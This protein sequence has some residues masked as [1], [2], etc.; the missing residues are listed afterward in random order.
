[1]Q[2]YDIHKYYLGKLCKHNHNYLNTNNTLRR[3]NGG[4]CVTCEKNR[5]KTIEY[6]IKNIKWIKNWR[7]KQSKEQKD[8]LKLLDAKNKRFLRA[9]DYNTLITGRLHSRKTKALKKNNIVED[10]SPSDFIKICN[11][12]NN[13]C[14]YCGRIF[15]NIKEIEIEHVIPISKK[16]SHSVNNIVPSC[17]KC[18]ASKKAQLIDEWYINQ[19]FYNVERYRN[20]KIHISNKPPEFRQQNLLHSWQ[21]NS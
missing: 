4:H 12:F 17:K 18:N 15:D 13:Q 11:K 9:N 19:S 7:D 3:K 8:K 5:K 14:A 2:N 16:G 21:Y 20:I 1:M 10:V 6:K